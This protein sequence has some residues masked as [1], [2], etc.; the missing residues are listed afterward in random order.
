MNALPGFFCLKIPI[1]LLVFGLVFWTAPHFA[2]ATDSDSA[3]ADKPI[4]TATKKDASAKQKNATP[5]QKSATAKKKDPPSKTDD[6]K[7]GGDKGGAGVGPPTVHGCQGN[8]CFNNPPEPP[9]PKPKCHFEK[10]I[11][12]CE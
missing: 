4:A 3:S 9:Q 2:L 6:S 1:K 11:K 7:S 12:I 10:G 8:S 5:K